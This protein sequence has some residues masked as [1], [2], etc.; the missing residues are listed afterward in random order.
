[1]GVRVIPSFFFVLA[2]TNCP[3]R[4]RRLNEMTDKK[5]PTRDIDAEIKALR[6]RIVT[7]VEERAQKSAKKL[8]KDIDERVAEFTK[9]LRERGL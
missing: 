7:E 6:D 3:Q 4:R 5:K 8:I 2:F 9:T 1:M